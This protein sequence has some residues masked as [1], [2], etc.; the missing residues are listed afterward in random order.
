M[1]TVSFQPAL[2]PFPTER[3]ST[4]SRLGLLKLLSPQRIKAGWREMR[5]TLAV[6]KPNRVG[7]ICGEGPGP[8]WDVNHLSGLC[9]D[10]TIYSTFQMPCQVLECNPFTSW[11]PC[12]QC[13]ANSIEQMWAFLTEGLNFTEASICSVETSEYSAPLLKLLAPV[14]STFSAKIVE[15]LITQLK[16]SPSFFFNVTCFYHTIQQNLRFVSSHITQH[17]TCT[18]QRWLNW[19][20]TGKDRHFGEAVSVKI[21][22]K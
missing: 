16:L 11:G 7:G 15:C 21:C 22:K 12:I 8:G 18:K 17:G 14:A 5:Y 9:L 19:L 20:T 1:E 13:W 4:L 10:E 6:S 3:K 2:L